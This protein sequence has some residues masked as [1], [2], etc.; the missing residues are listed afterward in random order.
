V[1][2]K[3]IH[4]PHEHGKITVEAVRSHLE[5]VGNQHHVQPRVISISQTTELGTIYHPEEIRMLA[6]FAHAHGLLLHMDGARL[7]NAAAALGLSLRALTR[8]VGVDFLSFGGT[9]IGMMYGEAVVF[10]DALRSQEFKYVRKQGMQLA[11]KMR[12]ISAQFEALFINDLWLKNAKH[13]NA[14]AK[15]L[16]ER[17]RKECSQVKITH[18]VEA[19]VVFA[20]VPP[21]IVERLLQHTFFWMWDSALSEVRWM[22]SWDTCEEDIETFVQLIKKLMQ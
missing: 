5:G 21:A 17:V 12:F 20:I 19:N 6:E 10:F 15:L 3:L 16:E 14:M 8:D 22:T 9:K 2:C 7:S 1:G 4:V 13:A 18:P 11:S